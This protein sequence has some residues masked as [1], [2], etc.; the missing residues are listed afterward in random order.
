MTCLSAGGLLI[1]IP[2]GFTI[3]SQTRAAI[4][5]HASL[6]THS[7]GERIRDELFK[8][9]VSEAAHPHLVEMQQAGLLQAIF[10]GLEATASDP[11]LRSLQTLEIILNGFTLFP[12]DNA[13][14]LSEEFHEYRKACLKFAVLLRPMVQSRQAAAISL[15]RLSKRDTPRIGCLLR[16]RGPFREIG[17]RPRARPPAVSAFQEDPGSPRC[18]TPL[19]RKPQPN[20]GLGFHSHPPWRPPIKKSC[21]PFHQVQD[22]S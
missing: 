22:F 6:I 12:P 18:G 2:T 9:V 11:S 21:P 19:A 1:R 15:L 5:C 17:I 4:G 7:A 16:S 10:P 20:R 14:L 8:L 3:D 13:A